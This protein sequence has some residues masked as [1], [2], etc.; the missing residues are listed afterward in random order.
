MKA[1]GSNSTSQLE[2]MLFNKIVE[3]GNQ[4]ISLQILL[5]SLTDLIVEKGIINKEELEDM[6]DDKV[7][8]ANN[9]VKEHLKKENKQKLSEIDFMLHFGEPGEA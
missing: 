9:L 5:Y 6:I 3:Q 4:L 8:K 1:S 2:E 7:K